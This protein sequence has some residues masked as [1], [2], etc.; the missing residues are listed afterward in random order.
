MKKGQS[1][2]QCLHCLES[3]TD[4]ERLF[5]NETNDPRHSFQ[6]G[7]ENTLPVYFWVV[8]CSNLTKYLLYRISLVLF[9]FFEKN[10][11]P[12]PICIGKTFHLSI[13]TCVTERNFHPIDTHFRCC[14]CCCSICDINIQRPMVKRT[15][16]K[17]KPRLHCVRNVSA[18]EIFHMNASTF[19]AP[20]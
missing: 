19:G 11:H 5:S 3:V 8:I 15:N 4:T 2:Q 12:F 14:C 6:I 13:W 17:K 9:S 10:E 16:R 20:M 7:V 18:F 1:L